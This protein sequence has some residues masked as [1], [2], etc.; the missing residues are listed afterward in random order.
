MSRRSLRRAGSPRC[1]WCRCCCRCNRLRRLPVPACRPIRSSF[2]SRRSDRTSGVLRGTIVLTSEQRRLIFRSPGTMP[3]QPGTR[4][5]A[6]AR[7]R[8]HRARGD[9]EGAAEPGRDHRSVS[10]ADLARAARRRRATDLRQSDRCQPLS[11][12]DRSGRKARRRHARDPASGCDISSPG[13]PQL[14]YP[15]L[16]GDAFPDCFH[17]SSTGNIHFH[18]THTNPDTTG[19]QRAAGDPAV[20]ARSEDADAAESRRSSANEAVRGFLQ[21]AARRSC[22][23]TCSPPIRRP[24]TTRRSGPARRPAPGPTEQMELLQAY[25]K[26]TGQDLWGTN[27]R[28]IDQRTTGRNTT[29]API[30]IAS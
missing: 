26:R 21:G 27:K 11:L 20:A 22:A 15:L 23:P 1:R 12:F 29:S 8:V 14:G 3:G 17:G 9:A 25:D 13:D 5:P 24:G 10:W 6:A 18:G 19:R 30:R 7:A 2:R 16:G 28:M 4:L